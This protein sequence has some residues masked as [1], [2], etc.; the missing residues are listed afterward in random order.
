MA[1]SALDPALGVH[2]GQGVQKSVHHPSIPGQQIP[3]LGR[4]GSLQGSPV[5]TPN[6]QFLFGFI[7]VVPV[8]KSPQHLLPPIPK[9]FLEHVVDVPD[10]GSVVPVFSDHIHDRRL[11]EQFLVPPFRWSQERVPTVFAP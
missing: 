7:S 6:L 11:A 2:L 10:E 4:E 9:D 8:Q 3:S 1:P 5:P